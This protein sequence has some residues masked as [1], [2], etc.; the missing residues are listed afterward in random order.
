MAAVALAERIPEEDL[1]K[2]VIDSGGFEIRDVDGGEEPFL[3]ST[4]NRGP[5]YVDIK[6]RV[7]WRPLFDTLCQQSA[8]RL[9]EAEAKFDFVSGNATGGMVPAFRTLE[10]Y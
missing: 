2:M 1:C 3:Y 6:G 9:I 4:K 10:H 5:G 8:L 7:G